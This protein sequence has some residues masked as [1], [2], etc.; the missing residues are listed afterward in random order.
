ME[1]APAI[2]KNNDQ[3]L[4]TCILYE[5]LEKKPIFDS[6]RNFC[7]LVGQDAMEYPEFEFWY[8]RFYHGQVDFDYDR[9]ADPVPKTL[10]DI[11]ISSLYKITEHLDTVERTYLRSMNKA[12]KDIADSHAPSFDKME[13]TAYGGCSMEWR[14]DNNAF[15]CYRK[16]KGCVLQKPNGSKIKSR[17]S[18]LKVG[19]KYLRLLWKIPGIK[20]NHFSITL[21]SETRILDDLLPLPFTPKS[22]Y[23]CGTNLDESL[24]LLSAINPGELES[25]N[26]SSGYM[27]EREN[28][29]KFFETEQFKQTKHIEF[30]SLLKVEDLGRF[31]HLKSLK[32][33]L[34][35]PEP[36][37]FQ[38][39]RDII[40]SFEKLESCELTFSK[41]ENEVQFRRIAEALGVEIPFGPL[42]I[43]KHRYQIP[44]SNEYLEFKMEDE[45]HSSSIKIV[46]IR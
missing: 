17:D 22:V 35:F 13:I 29:S 14:L 30:R 19:I 45:D 31:S 27:D 24:Q 41:F 25:I 44:E 9:S 11:P 34:Q 38:R 18:Y 21:L 5:V 3:S 26:F 42:Q 46:K 7:N 16:N 43:I 33:E 2:I 37:G 36:E 8:Y 20:V 23:I 12:I 39:I 6:Y 1:Q 15:H 10:M 28:V 4:K 40:S 32:C